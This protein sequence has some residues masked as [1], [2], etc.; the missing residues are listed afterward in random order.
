MSLTSQFGSVLTPHCVPQ[1][2]VWCLD[3]QMHSV[4]ICWMRRWDGRRKPA[5]FLVSLPS[6]TT[7]FLAEGCC[8]LIAILL[9]LDL[10]PI[11]IPKLSSNKR[12][13]HKIVSLL[14]LQVYKQM[15]DDGLAGM[16]ERQMEH[17]MRGKTHPGGPCQPWAVFSNCGSN[18]RSLGA[19]G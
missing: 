3:H 12:L 6:T 16:L 15:P 18:F 5:G 9:Y 11:F 13:S 19:Q 17:L 8:Y 7:P 10:N 1:H 14:S 2:Q 4:N